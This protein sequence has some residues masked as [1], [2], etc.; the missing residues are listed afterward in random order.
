V[1]GVSGADAPGVA[2]AHSGTKYRT[3]VADPPWEVQRSHGGANWRN[4]QR[5]RPDMPYGTMTIDE[6]KALPV[7][8]LAATDAHLYLWTIQ[9]HLEATFDVARAWGFK[10]SAVL[11]WCK[12]RGGFVGGTYFSN[13]E[14]CLFCRRGTLAATQRVNSQWFEWPKGEHSAKPEAFLDMVEAT[15]PGPYVELFARRARFGWDYWGNESLGTA[16]MEEAA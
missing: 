7:R 1:S 5:D 15:S 10:S 14:F 4:G 13:L 6:I 8:E 12:P 3:I 2:D 11:G 9:R 16:S